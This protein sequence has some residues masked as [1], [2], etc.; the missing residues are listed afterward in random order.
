MERA[1]GAEREARAAR[2]EAAGARAAAERA[3]AAL[4]VWGGGVSRSD[5]DHGRH[6]HEDRRSPQ[7][8]Q[9]SAIALEPSFTTAEKSCS[10][11]SSG[12][13]GLVP[14]LK[15]RTALLFP[16]APSA[17][18]PPPVTAFGGGGGGRGSSAA[19]APLTSSVGGASSSSAVSCSVESSN[20]HKSSLDAMEAL[21]SERTAAAFWG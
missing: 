9:Y 13:G 10:S 11:G 15:T 5:Q 17:P 20:A 4:S 12:G 16:R 3:E 6:H 14:E 8:H 7:P 19:A 2:A 21:L 18:L 1:R